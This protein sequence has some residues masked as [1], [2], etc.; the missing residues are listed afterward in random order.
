MA[1]FHFILYCTIAFSYAAVNRINQAF[2]EISRN[3][4]F[5]KFQAVQLNIQQYKPEEGIEI[6]NKGR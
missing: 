5:P 2:E 3:L 6:S 1:Y 4:I